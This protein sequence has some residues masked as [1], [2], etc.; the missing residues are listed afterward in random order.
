ME[1]CNACPI[2][3]LGGNQVAECLELGCS[4]CDDDFRMAALANGVADEACAEVCRFCARLVLVWVNGCFD[5]GFHMRV[6]A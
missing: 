6:G 1:R 5:L 3:A 2:D 4:R